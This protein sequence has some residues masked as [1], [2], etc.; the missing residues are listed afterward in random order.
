[1]L[2]MHILDSLIEISRAL[3]E[4][5]EPLAWRGKCARKHLVL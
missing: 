1:M 2:L 5:L 3:V 4:A